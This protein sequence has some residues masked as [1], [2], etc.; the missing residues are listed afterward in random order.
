AAWG[1]HQ[2]PMETAPALDLPAESGRFAAFPAQRPDVVETGPCGPTPD[3]AQLIGTDV[4]GVQRA[5]VGQRGGKLHALAAATGARIPHQLAR[6]GLD[7]AADLLA[8]PVLDLEGP[9][10]IGRQLIDP[11]LARHPQ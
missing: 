11:A 1:V 7:G 10:A 3:L 5:P 2:H 9:R 6:T 8:G 4:G